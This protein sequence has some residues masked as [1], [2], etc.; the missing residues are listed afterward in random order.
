M[1]FQPITFQP[2]SFEQA[3]PFASGF[4]G[5]QNVYRNFLQNKY[6]P[7]TLQAEAASKL[8]YANLMGP[9]FLTK[10]MSNPALLAN[11]PEEIKAP[12]LNKL[13]QAG[14]GQGT[15]ATFLN[16]DGLSSMLAQPENKPFF[17]QPNQQNV[18]QN[19]PENISSQANGSYG[20]QPYEM[21]NTTPQ[22]FAERQA[23]Y[24]GIVKEG[25]KT[26]ELRSE[27]I[28]T[29]GDQYESGLRLG[30][31]F[32]NL[33]SILTNP[34]F[35][36]L[37]NQ[38]P[39]FQDKQLQ[40]LSKFGTPQQ[41]QLVGD[42][43]TTTQEIVRDTVNTFQGQ[44]LKSEVDISNNM[45]VK[46][47]DTFNVALGKVQAA[48]LYKD[49]NMKRIGI[50]SD[51]MQKQHISKINALEKADKMIDGKSIRNKIDNLL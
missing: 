11:I 13:V 16:P 7:L 9:Q 28:K 49:L 42:F 35:Q 48:M 25:Q 1:A 51:L 34:E 31:K 18:S 44:R 24:E 45:K 14:S 39:L 6:L 47:N 15:G 36:K 21:N 43:I 29:F 5:G 8:A 40:A 41:Q 33:S 50:A 37:R 26:G 12:L 20:Y 10:I 17:N 46:E 4:Q 38:L 27:D 32:N 30:D 3:N 23:E 19:I 2:L 22:N